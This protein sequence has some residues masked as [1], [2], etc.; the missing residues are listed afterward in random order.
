M[1]WLSNI[2]K[3]SDDNEIKALQT[4]VDSIKALQG[5][6]SG[7]YQHIYTYSYNGE[8]NLGEIGPI[9][10]YDVDYQAIRA[11]SWQS[12][13]E[14]EIAQTVLNKFS[15]WVIGQ[16]L[17]LQAEPEKLTLKSEGI[18]FD[19]EEFN[20]IIEPR[21]KTWARSNNSDY[22]QNENFISIQN[23]AFKS[24]I[25]GGDCLVV[26]RVKK[27]RN[28]VQL[29]DGCHVQRPP[30]AAFGRLDNGN[31]VINGVE[32]DSKGNHV[33]Y[34]V[35]KRG[36][37]NKFERI[38]AKNPG[39]SQRM[40]FLVYGS[41]YRLGETRGMPLI[42]TVL[43]TIKKLERYKE[44]TVGSAEERQKVAYFL[45]LGVQSTGENPLLGQM[46]AAYNADTPGELP[47]TN[48]GKELADKVAAST[49]KQTF[50]L[51]IDSTMKILES[52]NELYFKD[53]YSVNINLICS[54]I[55]IPPNVAMSLYDSNYSAS[56]A[57]IKDWEHVL[58][59]FRAHFASM[60]HQPIYNLY[61]EIQILTNKVQATGY[62]KALATGN[63]YVVE[64][65]RTARFIGASVPN[66]DPVKEV[67]AEREKLGEL[68]THLPLTTLEAATEALDSGDSM[69][70]IRQ[71]EKELK[72]TILDKKEE[73]AIEPKN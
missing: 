39:K 36:L 50:N 57:A 15:I 1:S 14:S 2:I 71:F 67:R 3:R 31:E 43:E 35:K 58:R 18:K 56:R 22:S 34:H 51:P 62:L 49:N 10:N 13:L 38:V 9:I 37:E 45:E 69:S 28:S 11:R 54:S 42:A 24:A 32:V 59:T 19:T 7:H 73:P 68:A 64:A 21:F 8:K 33:A 40:A 46:A 30:S 47:V 23:M 53:F 29:I 25:I 63:D 66:I 72:S 16:G 26:Q 17:K 6:T 20:D 27:G 70:N 5:S 12:Y 65:Y 52:K 61:L 44:A 55:G 41:K 60:F 48:D 4:E